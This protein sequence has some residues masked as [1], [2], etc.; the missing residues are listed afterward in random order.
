MTEQIGSRMPADDGKEVCHDGKLCF[1]TPKGH[2]CLQTLVPVR[3]AGILAP[4]RIEVKRGGCR[5]EWTEEGIWTDLS[6]MPV[7]NPG[8]LRPY[9]G[10][11][12]R[13]R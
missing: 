5:T 1:N 4:D 13:N 7:D 3:H 8:T 9:L 12:R 11:D 10:M 2:V 6:Q